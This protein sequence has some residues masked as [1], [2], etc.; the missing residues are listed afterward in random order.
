MAAALAVPA[1]LA[2][3]SDA[4]SAE[5]RAAGIGAWAGFLMLGFSLGPLIGGALTHYVGWRAIF[6]ASSAIMLAASAGFAVARHAATL[7]SKPIGRFDW[8][9]FVCWPPSWAR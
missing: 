5:H 4:G 1:T 9:G 8:V 6:W 7:G 3:V 2:A